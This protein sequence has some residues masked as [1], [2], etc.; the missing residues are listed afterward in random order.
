MNCYLLSYR[1]KNLPNLLKYFSY[2]RISEIEG[3]QALNTLKSLKFS[4]D[5]RS[6]TLIPKDYLG[7]I[8]SSRSQVAILLILIILCT[9]QLQTRKS[10]FPCTVPTKDCTSLC[11]CILYRLERNTVKKL[12]PH[13]CCTETFNIKVTECKSKY[14]GILSSSQTV[15]RERSGTI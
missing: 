7:N 3:L 6:R 5:I 10:D 14:P 11:V 9:K 12:I 15:S 2:I 4:S 13:C 1:D 8:C